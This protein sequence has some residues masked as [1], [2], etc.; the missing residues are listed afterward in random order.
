MHCLSDFIPWN[1]VSV[2]G[3]FVGH[4]QELIRTEVLPYQREA[5]N[6]QIAGAEPSHCLD[7]FRAAA[8]KKG[9]IQFHGQPF[10]RCLFHLRRGTAFLLADSVRSPEAPGE[11]IPPQ[12]FHSICSDHCFRSSLHI[13]AKNT[14]FHASSCQLQ[15]M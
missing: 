11:M 8:E 10:H 13:A 1:Q 12:R 6:D 5:L 14:D 7:N 4:I 15:S 2:T 3:N 9:H